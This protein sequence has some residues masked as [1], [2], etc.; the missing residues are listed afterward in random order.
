MTSLQCPALSTPTLPSGA[1]KPA[2]WRSVSSPGPVR[3]P[4]GPASTPGASSRPAVGTLVVAAAQTAQ[5]ATFWATSLPLP[6]LSTVTSSP[7]LTATHSPSRLTP[8]VALTRPHPS[9]PSWLPSPPH[10][11]PRA[12][13]TAR[14]RCP[15][16]AYRLST[17]P[18]R[19]SSTWAGR[20]AASPWMAPKR[21]LT[22]AGHW[23]SSPSSPQR[24]LEMI[25]SKPMA[26]L[27]FLQ[28]HSLG[29][30]PLPCPT[31]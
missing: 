7:R 24:N 25:G 16:S 17:R 23:G 1:P 18:T 5:T 4:S 3:L 14:P 12:P 31:S 10:V 30:F 22:P 8:R 29:P 15:R 19:P 28:E 2:A 6:T 20:P 21:E 13:L 26:R 9:T 11:L 27:C